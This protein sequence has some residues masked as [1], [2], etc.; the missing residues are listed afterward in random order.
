MKAVMPNM[1]FMVVSGP[2]VGDE[3]VVRV[4]DVEVEVEEE[5]EVG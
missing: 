2:K 4:V 5:R 1:R 3:G